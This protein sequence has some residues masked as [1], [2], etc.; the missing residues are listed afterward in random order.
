[1]QIEVEARGG[2]TV[3]WPE[4]EAWLLVSPCGLAHWTW[5]GHVLGR[6]IV[7]LA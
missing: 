1:M 2:L 4:F 6:A 5:R 7:G 3:F